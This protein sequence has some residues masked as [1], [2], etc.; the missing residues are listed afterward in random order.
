MKTKIPQEKELKELPGSNVLEKLRGMA[1]KKKWD[2]VDALKD[3]IERGTPL[4]RL[5]GVKLE[6]YGIRHAKIRMPIKTNHD[7]SGYMF[8]SS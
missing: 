8:M 6:D 1:L 2:D 5:T 3:W 4:N 7:P